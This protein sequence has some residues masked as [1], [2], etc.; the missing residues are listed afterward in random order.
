VLGSGSL[1][2]ARRRRAAVARAADAFLFEAAIPSL[3]GV[4]LVRCL[5]IALA[6]SRS[7]LLEVGF[8]YLQISSAR[9]LTAA[10]RSSSRSSSVK[11]LD[12]RGLAGAGGFCCPF[13]ASP[14]SDPAHRGILRPAARIEWAACAD[15]SSYAAPRAVRL[16]QM[17]LR[18]LDA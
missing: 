8:R 17:G 5:E 7:A 1:V 3:R 11:D 2:G 4:D 15:A 9:G 13:A 14:D 10:A 16:L 6:R 12:G 18:Q